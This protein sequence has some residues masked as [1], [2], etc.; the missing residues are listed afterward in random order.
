MTSIGYAL[1]SEEHPPRDLV[2]HAVAAE[3]AGFEFALVSDH[4]HPWIDRQGQSPFVWSV[5]GAIAVVTRRL[6]V[7]TGVTCPTIRTHPAIIAHAAAT[8]ANMFEGRFFLGVGTGENL[9]EHVLGDPWPRYETRREMLIEAVYVMRELWRGELLSHEGAHYSVEN[10]RLYTLPEAPPDIMVAA[11]GKESAQ[12]AGEIGDGLIGTAPN[13]DLVNAF[14]RGGGNGKPRYG[15]VTVCWA[16]NRDEA[17]RTAHEWWPTSAI[18]GELSQELALPRHFEQ[19]AE[20][21]TPEKVAESVVCGP[22]PEQHLAKI[23]EYAD[24]GFDHIYI[25]QVGPD[26]A[27]FLRF[28]ERELLPRAGGVMARASA[29]A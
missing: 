4:F 21:V 22:D 10:A 15:Q 14:E 19:A 20:L 23:H 8:T 18:P 29:S 17:V 28:F 13:A 7:G 3:R 2:A 24:A 27:G 5:L 6:R 9:N 1:S 26:Q 25:H 11:S 16:A 12:T